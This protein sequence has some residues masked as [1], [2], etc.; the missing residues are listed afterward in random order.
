MTAL[1]AALLAAAA[2]LL[3]V[4]GPATFRVRGW[5]TQKGTDVRG[6]VRALGRRVGGRLAVGPAARRRVARERAD[7]L[8]ALGALSAELDAGLAPDQALIRAGGDPSVWPQ[9]TRAAEWGGPISDAL[10]RDAQRVPVLA[11]VA[12]CWR[13]GAQG[14]GLA[15]SLKSVA[16]SSRAAEDVRVEME[17]QLAGPRATARLLSLLPLVGVGLGAMLGADP[18]GWLTSTLPG[19]LCLVAGC[20][21]TAIGVWWTGRIAAGVERRL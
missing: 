12:A 1:L 10:D 20:L 18:L 5:T 11:Q 3:L 19:R 14:S 9:A 17:G 15:S 6:R 21:L 7:V 13:V 16:H 2:A 4:D 8:R